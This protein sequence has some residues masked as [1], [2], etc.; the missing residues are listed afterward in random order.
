VLMLTTL[1][2]AGDPSA[3][4]WK[5]LAPTKMLPPRASFASAYAG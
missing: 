3:L 1:S 2:L 5:K 4:T